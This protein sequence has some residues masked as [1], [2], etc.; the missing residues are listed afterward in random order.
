MTHQLDADEALLAR[1]GRAAQAAELARPVRRKIDPL[2]EAMGLPNPVWLNAI[3]NKT[4]DGRCVLYSGPNRCSA[5]A[6]H[7]AWIGCT[8]GE[9]LDKSGVCERHAE[10]MSKY[11]TLHCERCWNAVREISDARIIKIEAINDDDDQD[12]GTAMAPSPDLLP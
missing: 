8:V 12:P 5:T 3:E 9:H 1:S 7:W 2:Q 10:A 4:P 6:T 11:P